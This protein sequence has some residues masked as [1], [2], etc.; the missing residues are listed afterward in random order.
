MNK[1]FTKIAG[2]VLGLTMAVGVGVGIASNSN[3]GEVK[4]DSYT[5]SYTDFTTTSYAD[6][7][8][9]HTKGNLKYNSYQV[10][11]SSNKMQWQKSKGY[12][13]NTEGIQGLTGVTTDNVTG[14]SFTITYGSSKDSGCTSESCTSGLTFFKVSVGGATGKCDSI[15]IS[16][17]AAPTKTL[18]SISISSSDHRSFDVGDTFVGESVTAYYDD[19]TDA[20]VTSSATYSGYNMSTAGNQTVTASYTEGSVTKTA[21]YS[22]TVNAVTLYNVTFNLQGH[23]SAIAQ[24][25]KKA[26]SLVD[27]PTDPTETGWNFGGWYK[28][29]GCSNEWDFETDT[30]SGDTTLYA[31]WEKEPEYVKITDLN[32]ADRVFITTV[33]DSVN[34]YIPAATTSSAP[35]AQTCTIVNDK[36][37]GVDSSN[38]FTVTKSG[39][40]FVF[41]NSDGKYLYTTNNNNGLR[42]DTTSDS[43][44][45]T[46]T[47]NGFKMCSAS[48]SRY[49]GVYQTSDWRT[50][51]S[52]SHTNYGG[53]GEAINF[54]GFTK[55]IVP[56][57][58]IE[59]RDYPTTDLDIGAQ[60]QL[61]YYGLDSEAEVWRGNVFY[62]TSNSSVATVSATGL[63]EAVGEGTADITVY[64]NAGVSGAKVESEP[65]TVTVLANPERIN[66]PQGIYP[67][68][69][70][71]SEKKKYDPV[72]V[73]EFEI[74]AKSGR[75]WY[76]NFNISITDVTT[77]YASEYVLAAGS[78]IYSITNNSNAKIKS[79]SVDWFIG[80]GHGAA[81]LFVGS[82]TTP[83]S[84]TEGSG[85]TGT[86]YN[87]NLETSENIRLDATSADASCGFYSLTVTF[88]VS[89]EEEEFLSLV[90]SKGPSWSK[91]TYKVGETPVSTG[92]IATA[93]YT[94]D[95]ETISSSVD[96][97]S[98][99]TNWSFNPSKLSLNDTSFTVTASWDSHT[100]AAFVVTGIT[101]EEI[102]GPIASGRYFIC[103][104][105][106]QAILNAVES[107]SSPTFTNIHD[108]TARAFDFVLI[109][110]NEYVISTTISETTYYLMDDT[111]SGDK[112]NDKVRVK[113]SASTS[114]NS[115][116]WI[117]TKDNENNCFELKT[118]T[119]GSLWRYLATYN[120][121]SDWRGYL[122]NSTTTANYEIHLVEE[123]EMFA[124]NFL[125]YFTA[126]CLNDGYESEN[127]HWSDA[128]DQFALMSVENKAVFTNGSSSEQSIVN[129]LARYDRIVSK[130]P[131][132][133]NDFMG[134]NPSSNAASLPISDLFSKVSNN[135]IA[136]VIVSLASLTAIGGYFFIR[137]RKEN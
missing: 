110:D 123:K 80:S 131:S 121:N 103:N 47:T 104:S 9:D 72:D 112:N 109:N 81:D 1:F 84:Y 62:T 106:S 58:S 49:V 89:N 127:M 77:A 85:G 98:V 34:Y 31:K 129:T 130:Y 126:G 113:S 29:A 68:T 92:L 59:L 3:A 134:R 73:G 38:L 54:Y 20:D 64:A 21:T 76:K 36:I 117:I 79:L 96:V 27:K 45:V 101:V 22:I 107:T 37:S 137:R 136:I 66:L 83:A 128:A 19:D 17:S 57:E 42:I 33:K 90:V 87:Y 91:T 100:S 125:D 12:I 44:T 86:V 67:V 11:Q 82:S 48:Q 40:N 102:T 122:N 39:D 124:N 4:A 63:L 43:W 70:S 78:G 46:S 18:S 75:T 24:Q 55:A 5:I 120:D 108:K 30:I 52:S 25:Q 56:L 93:N 114:I 10:Y 116:T 95:G 97:S 132:V 7:N 94:I 88:E 50:Y 26:G 41:K 2:L 118:N 28:E 99:V 53:S 105:S 111:I 16:Y 71:A 14:G 119:T 135:T 6:N 51:T 13:Y 74:I 115:P 69:I 23:G 15:T 32:T 35:T 133:F 60:Q 61:D 8:G 65:I